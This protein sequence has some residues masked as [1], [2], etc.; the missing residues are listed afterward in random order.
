MLRAAL[1]MQLVAATKRQPQQAKLP[2][3]ARNLARK[4]N[5]FK[6]NLFQFNPFLPHKLPKESLK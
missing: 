6:R 3:R 2:L 1:A 4:R 5:M